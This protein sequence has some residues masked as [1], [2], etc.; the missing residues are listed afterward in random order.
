MNLFKKMILSKITKLLVWLLLFGSAGAAGQQRFRYSSVLPAVQADG[1]YRII[2]QPD[3]R[4]KC[5]AGMS[6]LRIMNADQQFVPYV[7][8][9]DQPFAAGGKFIAFPEIR[10][11]AAVD[12][13]T[14]FV[15]ENTLGRPV[16][17]LYLKMR[18]TAVSRKADLT[19]SDDQQHWYAIKESIS[20]QDAGSGADSGGNYFQALNFPSSAYRYLKI[21]ISNANRAAVAVLAAGIVDQRQVSPHYLKLPDPVIR[22]K[23]SAGVSLITARFKGSYQLD[24]LVLALSGQKYYRRHL[25]IYDLNAAGRPLIAA[26][27]ISSDA[28][29]TLNLSV[30]TSRIALEIDNGDNPVLRIQGIT[31]Y[32][33]ELAVVCYLEQGKS[34]SLLFGDRK[35]AAPDYDLKFFE[36]S[37]Q[38]DTRLL[39]HGGITVNPLYQ[40][41]QVKSNASHAIFSGWTIWAAIIVVAALLG[42]LTWRMVREVNERAKENGGNP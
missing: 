39:A 15:V 12:S 4:A 31:G 40:P 14:T 36:D 17:E 23:D 35:A 37:L 1:L 26:Q 7:L 24:R 33:S 13:V 9:G 21:R 25:R 41:G 34:Y 22:Q 11:A 29:S 28:P 5:A 10:Q 42:F 32:Q 27:V 8:S 19:G 16:K 6:D 30:R 20:L 3:L 18:N 2:L 38:K